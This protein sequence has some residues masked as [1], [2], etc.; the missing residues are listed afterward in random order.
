MGEEIWKPIILD[1]HET[2]YS[3]SNYG[4]VRNNSTKTLLSGTVANNGYRMV[5]LRYRINKVCSVHRLV[6]KAFK[7]C[8]EMDDLQVNHIDGNK[9]NN[10]LD[11]LEWCTALENM[12]HSFATGLQKN[13]SYPIYQYDLNGNYITSYINASEAARCLG[14]DQ[15]NILRCI[16]GE[17]THARQYQF[18][19]EQH[20][21]IRPWY[22]WKK[23][24]VFVYTDDGQLV[25]TY[26][27]QQAAAQAFGVG[28]AS[29]SR[30]MKQTRK[31]PGFVFSP[32]PL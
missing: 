11:N 30:Y 10:R 21:K 3:V 25:N 5:H 15:G 8:A 20:D 6:M 7:P 28:E 19:K 32:R 16:H 4:N 13:K 29:V 12:R 2:W 1:G 14:I 31:L 17:Q 24:Q 22:D 26:E 27:S 18:C 23:H 9:L